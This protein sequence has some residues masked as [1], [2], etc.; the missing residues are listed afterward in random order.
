[1]FKPAPWTLRKSATIACLL[2]LIPYVAAAPPQGFP[3]N[4]LPPTF[5]G[6]NPGYYGPYLPGHY[7]Y[8]NVNPSVYNNYAY[9]TL[10]NYSMSSSVPLPF[11]AQSYSSSPTG[12]PPAANLPATA[13]YGYGFREFPPSVPNLGEGGNR[14]VVLEVHL[15]TPDAQLW[16]EGQKTNHSGTWRWFISPP[17]VPGDHYL[18]DVRASWHEN[19]QEVTQNRQ[20]PVRAGQG[21]VVDFTKP[22]KSSAAPATRSS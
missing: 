21:I 11:G 17:L 15:P 16:V 1:M 4:A 6:P 7:Q 12:I 13:N 22:A 18:Y 3:T 20:V 9:P 14:R 8:G 5:Y 10:P 19:G 2:C